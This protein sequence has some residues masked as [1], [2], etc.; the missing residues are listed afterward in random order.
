MHPLLS[1]RASGVL[2]HLTSL[3]GPHGSGDLGAEAGNF[4]GWLQAA[5]QTLW[6]VLPLT[7]SGAGAS[8]Y[9]S[10]SAF[11]GPHPSSRW[12][13]LFGWQR[14]GSMAIREGTSP[15]HRVV[16]YASR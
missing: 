4:L 12:H 16:G 14:C 11:A 9:Q 6:Q 1:R 10:A 3:P 5:G 8:P 7:P 13:H 15:R 2:L